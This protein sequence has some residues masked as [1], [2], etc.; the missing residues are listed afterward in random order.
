MVDL[1]HSMHFLKSLV[2]DSHVGATARGKK[3]EGSTGPAIQEPVQTSFA[4]VSFG[5][6]TEFSHF[7]PAASITHHNAY[8]NH[9]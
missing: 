8:L 3:P 1:Q 9:L 2:V 4:C 5:R 7:H 6:I